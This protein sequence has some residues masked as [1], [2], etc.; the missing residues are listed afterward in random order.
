MLS[1]NWENWACSWLHSRSSF[2][3][4]QKSHR[5]QSRSH[6]CQ[7]RHRWR[8]QGLVKSNFMDEY[9]KSYKS[10][11]YDLFR[12]MHKSNSTIL[13]HVQ[14]HKRFQSHRRQQLLL[15]S[16]SAKK[17]SPSLLFHFSSKIV[18]PDSC[19]SANPTEKSRQKSWAET[20]P[21]QAHW[22]PPVQ[23]T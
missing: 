16:S 23:T 9:L 11:Y 12:I 20:S 19:N 10:S 14:I 8:I 5:Q 1:N 22:L 17:F 21:L 6:G 18:K 3:R 7:T 2:W 13:A 15:S 4:K